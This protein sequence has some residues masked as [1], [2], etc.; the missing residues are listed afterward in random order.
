MKLKCVKS[1]IQI[2]CFINFELLIFS[3]VSSFFLNDSTL[4]YD[5]KALDSNNGGATLDNTNNRQKLE[6]RKFQPRR[7][8]HTNK[9]RYDH[10]PMMEKSFGFVMNTSIINI[11]SEI[12]CLKTLSIVLSSS[13]VPRHQCYKW[14]SSQRNQSNS[15]RKRAVD[16]NDVQ[17]RIMQTVP[18][19]KYESLYATE[20]RQRHE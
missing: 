6:R 19:R 3:F 15:L 14:K 11:W 12:V 16:S 18:L 8:T 20:E 2:H 5:E 1:N 4:W 17:L 7:E 13:F 10:K 9:L